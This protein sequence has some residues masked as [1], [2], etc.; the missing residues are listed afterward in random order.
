MSEIGR[1]P[2][3]PNVRRCG[4]RCLSQ[5]DQPHG[6]YRRLC[7]RMRSRRRRQ[8]YV[9]EEHLAAH[10]EALALRL[11]EE[12]QRRLFFGAVRLMLPPI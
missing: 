11:A 7:W 2:Y 10:Q 6:T 9:A 4:K 12:R 3:V 1:L 8:R 5:C